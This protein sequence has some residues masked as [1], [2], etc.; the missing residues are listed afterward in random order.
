MEAGGGWGKFLEDKPHFNSILKAQ[1]YVRARLENKHLPFFLLSRDFQERHLIDS[2]I[3]TE[4]EDAFLENRK[5]SIAIM[6]VLSGGRDAFDSVTS[7]K[8]KLLIN[9][10]NLELKGQE[11]SA[12]RFSHIDMISSGM[13]LRRSDRSLVSDVE[14]DADS[15]TQDMKGRRLKDINKTRM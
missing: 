13:S 9:L 2:S 5:R 12:V 4:E 11:R 15:E 14:R 6:K 7:N 8:D 10:D 1:K 3:I